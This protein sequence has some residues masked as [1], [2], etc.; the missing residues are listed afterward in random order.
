MDNETKSIPRSHTL[1]D[2][3]YII[4]FKLQNYRDGEQINGCKGLGMVGIINGCIYKG[5][6]SGD[7]GYGI[8][9]CVDC[10]GGYTYLRTLY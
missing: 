2:S 1:Y 9:L 6:A 4:F 10:N 7:C 3:F 5:I 8:V